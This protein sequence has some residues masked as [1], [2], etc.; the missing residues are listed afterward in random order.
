MKIGANYSGNGTC[1]FVVWSPTAEKIEVKIADGSENLIAM[2]RDEEYYW[3]ARV[4]N[5]KAGQHYF[6]RINGEVDR[7]DPASNS[8]PEDV[9][10]PSEI[11]DH[12]SFQW[13]DEDW[14]GVPI[15]NFIIYE[16]HIGTLTDEGT[17]DAAVKRLDDIRDLGIT[18]VEVMPVSQY[19]GERNWG[20][21][22]V[23]PFAVQSSYGGAEGLKRFVD[24]CHK[25]GVAVILDV[26]YN[27]F[28]PAG[29]YLNNYGPYFTS[30][31]KT[32]WGEAVNF[33]EEYSDA[34]RNYFVENVLYWFRDFHIDALRLDAVHSI[35]DYSAKHILE[36]MAETTDHLSKTE[37]KKH[38]LILESDLNDVR[39]INPREIGGYGCDAQWSDDFHHSLHCLL[40]GENSGY[41]MDFGTIGDMVKAMKNSFV[42]TGQ[43]SRFRKRKHGND[44]SERPTYQFIVSM[45]NHDQIGNRAFGERLSSLVSF[46]AA[47]LA[48][49]VMMLSPYIP[50]LF[51]GEEYAEDTPFQ[52]F[53]SHSDP[54]LVKAVQDGRKEEFKA[55][56]WKSEVPD[57]QSEE[58]FVNSKLRWNKRQ[59][60]RH[61]VM[62]EFYKELIGLRNNLPAL[63][64]F[65][66]KDMNVIGIEDE[67]VIFSHRWKR[68][69]GLYCIMNFN[70]ME[71]TTFVPLPRGS[72]KKI[73]DSSEGKWMAKGSSMP[74]RLD[75]KQDVTIKEFSFALYELEMK[76]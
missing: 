43:Y 44:P 33:D 32:P 68:E 8:Q 30:K 39:Y 56:Q 37:G 59:E 2:K 64:N 53:V 17:F 61:K 7:S 50:M 4:E 52:Y 1:E 62:L 55:F 57:P 10:G 28:G 5:L 51:M 69:H 72:W 34:V 19:P 45:Q 14:E 38:F 35:Y 18:A 27:H 58:T 46:E 73:M 22:G 13:T 24:A 76:G 6:Y 20:Y 49:G 9:H 36:E 41:Y 40:T 42:Y 54:V 26:V 16:V 3:R 25:K 47:K 71:I 65:D 66:R 11:I 63:K 29:N 67:K 75:K 74:E 23:Y 31:Y 70:D 48:A 60:G 15:T 12:S 21:D